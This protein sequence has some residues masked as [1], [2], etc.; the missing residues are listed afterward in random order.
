MRLAAAA[1]TLTIAIPALAQNQPTSAQPPLRGP[2]V[3]ERSAR[4]SLVERDFSGKLKRLEMPPEEAALGLLR[5]DEATKAKTDAILA[6]RAEILDRIVTENIDLVVRFAGARQAGDR[7]EQLKL[8]EE[9]SK[10]LEPLS[11]RGKLIDELKG[12]LPR[13]KAS[14][15]DTLVNDYR[16]AAADDDVA[17]ART[18][19]EQLSRLQANL[20]ENLASLGSDVKRSYERTVAAKAA[21]FEQVLAQLS[22]RPEQES[23]IRGMVRDFVQETKGKPTPEQRRGLFMRIMALLDPD[24]QQT[25]VNAYLG[26]PTPGM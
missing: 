14:R 23:K 3:A 4:G 26:R 6:A 21:D 16:R 25:L 13:D 17:E 11:A 1:V 10:K 2:E 5:L 8:L 19:G 7:A 24:Q 15:L 20:R 18:R 22:L 12:V 9:F